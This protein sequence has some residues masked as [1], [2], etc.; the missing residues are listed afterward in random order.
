MKL[1]KALSLVLCVVLIC[2]VASNALAYA[3]GYRGAKIYGGTS[4]TRIV[5]NEAR[6]TNELYM[7]YYI[8]SDFR[9]NANFTFRGYE[10]GGSAGTGRASNAISFYPDDLNGTARGQDFFNEAP[11]Y[12]DVRGTVSSSS[13]SDYGL[14]NGY[15]R[16]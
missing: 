9:G 10:V 11:T 8:E 1:K 13:S 16:I 4:G 3:I 14:F 7:I 15:L 2:A 6:A 12:V 5:N